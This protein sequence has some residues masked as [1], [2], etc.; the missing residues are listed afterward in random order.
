MDSHHAGYAALLGAVGKCLHSP[1]VA[2]VNGPVTVVRG[3]LI[4]FLD[5]HCDA[6]GMKA[7][8]NEFMPPGVKTF[9]PSAWILQKKKVNFEGLK[10]VRV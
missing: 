10:E 1:F 9:T 3:A 7:Q 6:L 8:R 5:H 4:D 2:G